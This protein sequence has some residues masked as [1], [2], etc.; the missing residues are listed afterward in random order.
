MARRIQRLSISEMSQ[1]T[2]SSVMRLASIN[3][4]GSTMG[5]YHI[6][7]NIDKKEY[8]SP[9]DIGGMGKHWEQVGYEKSMADTLYVLSIAQGNERRG[10]G[11]ICGHE[12]V[13][14]W[15]GDRCAI[16]GDYFESDDDDPRFRNLYHV[17]DSNPKWRNI[18]TK[19]NKMWEA[20]S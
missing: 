12:L 15:A 7:V 4:K 2:G 19:V 10:G 13:G 14:R 3:Q 8:V 1:E 18:S 17:V 5:Q 16:V 11:D 9:W 20:V 6:L